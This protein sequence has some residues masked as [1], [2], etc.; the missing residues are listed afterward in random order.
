MQQR[1]A[2]LPRAALLKLVEA[3]RHAPCGTGIKAVHR[4][5]MEL[6]LRGVPR[7][8]APADLVTSTHSVTG[9]HLGGTSLK[10]HESNV[11]STFCGLDD[12]VVSQDGG[13]SLPNSP[14]LAQP[15]RDEREQRATCLVIGFAV[16]DGHHRS[17]HGRVQRAAKGVEE[18]RW[19][20]GEDRA[21]AARGGGASF[22][23]NGDE[24]EGVGGAEQVGPMARD[25]ACGADLGQPPPP[26]NGSLPM[27][28]PS[29][30][31][32][33]VFPLIATP[34]NRR[35]K[36]GQCCQARRVRR[37]QGRLL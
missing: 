6:G 22:I 16:V 30:M 14:G 9:C 35:S 27:T 7:V 1:R 29:G 13:Q 8:A 15:V 3:E 32:S 28:P 33:G 5:N 18:L 17:R 26:S 36:Y 34:P 19:L 24:V 11:M 12:D 4:L 31:R 23:V 2:S 10:V 20:G 37:N 25:A 21:Q